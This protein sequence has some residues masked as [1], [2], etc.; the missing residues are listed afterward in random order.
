[1]ILRI[2]CMDKR[3]FTVGVYDLLHIGHIELLRKAKSYGTYLIVAVQDSD[4]VLKYKPT[5]KL[6]YSTEERM[7]MVSSIMYVDE[8]L[9][10][11]DVDKIIEKVDFDVFAV[12]PD[13]THSG[14]KNAIK[15]CE[16]HGKE[17]VVIP[18]TEGISSTLLKE[19]I[20]N[21]TNGKC[22]I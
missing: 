18:R 9:T 13:Q 20:K 21:A 10:Y 5:C 3:V 17:V 6:V 7:Y 22:D 15:W 14:F 12:G 4:I 8:V 19:Q 16:N 11:T 2:N 1:M